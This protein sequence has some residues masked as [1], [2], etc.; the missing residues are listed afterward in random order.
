MGW[1]EGFAAL[2]TLVL[3]VATIRQAAGAERQ[4]R[5]AYGPSLAFRN[6]KA[7]GWERAGR[8]WPDLQWVPTEPQGDD[9]PPSLDSR[10]A[11]R[12]LCLKLLNIGLGP[13][14]AV[15]VTWACDTIS[16]MKKKSLQGSGAMEH[17]G[18]KT[19]RFHLESG[20][21]TISLHD[22]DWRR[23][24]VVPFRDLTDEVEVPLPRE[25]L[26]LC[27][28]LLELDEP[29]WPEL[30]AEVVCEDV[31]G[32]TLSKRFVVEIDLGWGGPD[33]SPGPVARIDVVVSESAPAS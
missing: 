8:R 15:H 20:N 27:M 7:V 4:R 30:I 29:I 18:P 26:R 19:Y 31:G 6:A 17:L 13:A 2:A 33:N 16:L 28:A 23:D 25:Y 9:R 3:A 1:V 10:T 11:P 5:S 24:F 32:T 12:P 22:V 14:R 21:S